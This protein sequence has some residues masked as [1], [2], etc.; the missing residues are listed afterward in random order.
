MYLSK[1]G[2]RTISWLWAISTPFNRHLKA[3]LD[4]IL[5]IW[6][7]FLREIIFHCLSTLCH[8]LCPQA[9]S[10]VKMPPCPAYLVHTWPLCSAGL[11][12]LGKQG[13]RSAPI[14][15]SENS[16]L[17]CPSC[18]MSSI[19]VELGGMDCTSCLGR[20]KKPKNLGVE[21]LSMQRVAVRA[22]KS[23]IWTWRQRP[24]WG[25]GKS[26]ISVM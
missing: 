20:V 23:M 2:A 6:F 7:H 21:T 17:S 8:I 12:L 25:W 14:Y 24:T 19:I 22:I 4:T 1:K 18:M 9:V 5:Q 16:F 10:Q 26:G 15:S 11:C 13:H 3:S